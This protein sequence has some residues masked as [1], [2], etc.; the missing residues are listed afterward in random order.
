M[1]CPASVKKGEVRNCYFAP[2]FSAEIASRIAVSLQHRQEM[3]HTATRGRRSLAV[4]LMDLTRI[5]FM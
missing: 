3:M 5:T 4:S 1:N 2:H